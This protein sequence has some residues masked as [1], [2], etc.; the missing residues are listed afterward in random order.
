[1]RGRLQNLSCALLVDEPVLKFALYSWKRNDLVR[2]F[3]G[4]YFFEHGHS[5]LLKITKAIDQ[6]GLL[7]LSFASSYL[8]FVIVILTKY[9]EASD[10]FGA[11]RPILDFS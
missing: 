2:R 7:Y 1:M 6:T 3:H 10:C 5:I 8:V 9:L 4:F 11:A